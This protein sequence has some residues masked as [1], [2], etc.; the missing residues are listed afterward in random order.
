LCDYSAD[1]ITD[2]AEAYHGAPVAVQIVGRRLTEE[3]TMAIA[4]E[5]GRLLGNAIAS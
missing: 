2:D 3:K 1:K 4:E 5:I